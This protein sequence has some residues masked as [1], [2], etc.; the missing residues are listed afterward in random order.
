LFKRFMAGPRVSVRPPK[1]HIRNMTAIARR[2]LRDEDGQD[3]VEY[4]LLSA[5]VGFAGLLAMDLI[6]RSIGV[7]YS[8]HVTGVDNLWESPSPSGAGG[9]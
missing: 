7:T 1:R 9:S 8:S 2:L 4:A 3:L 5:F 6:L